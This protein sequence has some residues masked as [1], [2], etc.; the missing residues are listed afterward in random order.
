MMKTALLVA[1]A[2]VTVSYALIWILAIA[3]ERRERLPAEK[4]SPVRPGPLDIAIGFVTNFFDT[5]GIGSFATTSS[6]FKLAGL[7]PDEQ[8]PGTMNVGH[9]AP[10]I[11]E[12]FI[13]VAVVQ[14]DVVTLVLMLAASAAGAWLGAGIVS[15]WPRRKIQIGMGAVL[16]AAAILMTLSQLQLLPGGGNAF[17]LTGVKLAIAVVGNA[18]LGA[19]MTLGIGLY[20]P[21]MVLVALMGMNARAAFPIMMGSCAFLM[22]VGSARFIRT[23]RYNLKAALG[24]SLGGIP[25]VLLA[26]FL[27]KSLPLDKVRWLVVAV[28]LYTAAMLL[29]SAHVEWQQK[30]QSPAP[31][32]TLAPAAPALEYPVGEED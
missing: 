26:A 14:V 19:L 27:V 20:A 18:V 21:C 12:A 13:Y 15:S 28:V 9:T 23:R 31:P 24:L 10:T 32:A 3:R 8:I 1:L 2:F 29:R 4:A 7:V 11:V 5:L 16:A 22:P 17:G 25:G 30:R 6:A